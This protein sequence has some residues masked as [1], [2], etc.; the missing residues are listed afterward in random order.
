MRSK[1][2]IR[3]A[4]VNRTFAPEWRW[5]VWLDE[6]HA[7]KRHW[8]DGCMLPG[9][10]ATNVGVYDS[11]QEAWDAG[12]LAQRFA[13]VRWRTIGGVGGHLEVVHDG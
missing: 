5:I 13:N 11:W 6:D 10:T 7:P 4:V 2:F 8:R 12:V 9:L 3:A 1:L